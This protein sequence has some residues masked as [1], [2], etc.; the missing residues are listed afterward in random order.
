MAIITHAQQDDVERPGQGGES[1][2]HVRLAC[3][4]VRR[5]RLHRHE[6]RLRG[7]PLQQRV[8][9]QSFVAVRAGRI[10]PAFVHQRDDQLAPVECSQAQRFQH[11]PGRAPTRQGDG[12]NP[13]HGNSVRQDGGDPLGNVGGGLRPGGE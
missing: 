8:A 2:F 11:R 4:G 1:A 5:I 10:D 3:I 12:R 13:A 7:G 6:A 9:H